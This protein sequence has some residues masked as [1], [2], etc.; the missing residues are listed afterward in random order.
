MSQGVRGRPDRTPSPCLSLSATWHGWV[1]YSF[2]QNIKEGNEGELDPC[3]AVFKDPSPP[4]PRLVRQLKM[5]AG[6]L[7]CRNL[8]PRPMVCHPGKHSIPKH[9]APELKDIMQRPEAGPS[10]W[11]GT[12][13]PPASHFWR[14]GR[15][16]G[17]GKGPQSFLSY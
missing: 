10:A 5:P 12:S 14:V 1:S 17:Q 11:P 2:F 4:T 13:L 7:V 3:L 6:T 15:N 9:M 16:C 8:A